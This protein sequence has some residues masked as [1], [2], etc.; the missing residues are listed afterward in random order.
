MRGWTVERVIGHDARGGALPTLRA[1]VEPAARGG[2]YY[3]PGGLW[4]MRGY[5]K[6]VRSNARSRDTEV[7]RRLR[8]ES[9]RL[10]GIT[11]PV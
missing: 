7:Q 6:R 8:E 4:E 11:L 1:A 9:E 2:D 3:G 10:T 5:P